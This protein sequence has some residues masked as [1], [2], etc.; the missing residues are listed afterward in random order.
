MVR[1]YA[2]KV[3]S[4]FDETCIIG[5]AS[6]SNICFHIAIS[7]REKKNPYRP[8]FSITLL[9]SIIHDHYTYSKQ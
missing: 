7:M 3:K 4:Q 9:L 2:Y 1:L 6:I 5:Y 8:G